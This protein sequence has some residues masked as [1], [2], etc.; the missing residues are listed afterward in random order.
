MKD[1]V[2][3]EN[4]SQGVILSGAQATLERV[5]IRDTK[6]DIGTQEYGNGIE[7]S[8]GQG[9]TT[10]TLRDS[11]LANNRYVGLALAGSSATIE[12]AVIRGTK[13]QASDNENGVGIIA[14]L[15]K[16]PAKLIIRDTIITHN[17]GNGL[18]IVGSD[19]VLERT[20]VSDTLPSVPQKLYGIGVQAQLGPGILDKNYKRTSNL[21]LRD[22]LV[23]KNRYMGIAIAGAALTLDRTILRDTLEQA[24]DKMNGFGMQVTA[25]EQPST[26][27]MQDSLI[28]RNRDMGILLGGATATLRRVVLRDT[29]PSVADGSSGIGIRV[30]TGEGQCASFTMEDSLVMRNRGL[31]VG[32]HCSGATIRRSVISD[33]MSERSCECYGDGVDGLLD[34]ATLG[35]S[36]CLIAKSA[37]VGLILG[38]SINGAPTR[39]KSY[40]RRC[41]I[42]GNVF[43]I[44][45]EEGVLPE[46]ADSNVFED[47]VRNEVAYG[48]NLKTPPIPKIPELPKL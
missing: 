22:C 37:R 13:P 25:L 40:V 1:C 12:R 7:A 38:A 14:W 20:I 26:L 30:G 8:R 19:A 48:Q 29:L 15:D 33:T 21:T 3:A 36:D 47:N 24:A 2:V 27:V 46:I 23:Q 28:Y 11:V 18:G 6:P 9:P 10:L 4:H 39:G 44:D 16:E 17:I 35:I 32:V 34:L 31:G 45:L 5:I 43:A 41:V 42:R